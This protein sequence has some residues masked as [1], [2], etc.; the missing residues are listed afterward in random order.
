MLID[1][2][3]ISTDIRR[4]SAKHFGTEHAGR[5]SNR[6]PRGRYTSSLAKA[7]NSPRIVASRSLFGQAETSDT[8]RAP[9]SAHSDCVDA[10]R[11]IRGSL[12]FGLR[13]SCR[14]TR[15]RIRNGR[16]ELGTLAAYSH[17]LSALM[18]RFTMLVFATFGIPRES[19]AERKPNASS[20][21]LARR[22]TG[23][24]RTAYPCRALHQPGRNRSPER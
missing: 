13:S 11:R 22:C 16:F 18:S 24:R 23:G 12:E 5:E 19:V 20:S 2:P 15:F 10:P 6:S 3:L 4:K 1:E 7:G 14:R 9:S 8:R 17:E 21:A